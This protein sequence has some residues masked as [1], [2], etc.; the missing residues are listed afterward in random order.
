MRGG[1][2][3]RDVLINNHRSLKYSLKKDDLKK[4]DLG[5]YHLYE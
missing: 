1:R 2:R 5:R 3:P 4:L